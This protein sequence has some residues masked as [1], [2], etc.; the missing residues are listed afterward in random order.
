MKIR[1]T[2]SND[3]NLNECYPEHNPEQHLRG[4]SYRSRNANIG[5]TV[6]FKFYNSKST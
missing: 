1:E 4:F 3:F 6:T 2:I 5:G